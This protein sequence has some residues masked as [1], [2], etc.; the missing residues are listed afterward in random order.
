MIGSLSVVG[1]GPGDQNLITPEVSL[2]IL[3]LRSYRLWAIS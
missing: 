1:L 2:A 3:K